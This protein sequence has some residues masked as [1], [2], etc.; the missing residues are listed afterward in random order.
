MITRGQPRLFRDDHGIGNHSFEAILFCIPEY[1]VH[2]TSVAA[3]NTI[4]YSLSLCL[5]CHHLP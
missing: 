1:T 4:D 5:S 3:T 2:Y